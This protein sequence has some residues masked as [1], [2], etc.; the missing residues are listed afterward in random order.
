MKNGKGV[1]KDLDLAATYFYKA[2]IGGY[3]ESRKLLD[4]VYSMADEF[5]K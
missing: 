2:M 1:N 5:K 4:E 3:F